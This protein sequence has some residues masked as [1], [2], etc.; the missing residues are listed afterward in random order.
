MNADSSGSDFFQEAEKIITVAQRNGATLRLI[1][2]LAIRF[3]CHGPHST[4]L[5]FYHDIDMFGLTKQLKVIYSVLNEF[6]Y[7]P[8]LLYN[9]KTG[10]TRLQFIRKPNGEHIDIFLDKFRMDHTL[11]FRRRLQLDSITIPVTDLLLTK[12]QIVRITDKD[13]RDVIAIIEDHEVTP[14]NSKEPLE[15]NYLSKLCSRDWGLEKTVL[16]NIDKIGVSIDKLEFVLPNDK[17]KLREKLN[18]LQECI[19]KGRK[20][21]RWRLRD[22]IG[23]RMKWY[24]V[25]EIGEGES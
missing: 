22:L 17:E 24:S 2:G 3:H 11:N 25:I 18:Q 14:E 5:R 6:R 10:G 21:I 16:D 8:N 20:G 7:A 23:T 1:G 12:L 9:T 4:H 19:R 13:V 15:L